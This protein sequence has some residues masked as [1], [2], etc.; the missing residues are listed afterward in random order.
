MDGKG[1]AIGRLCTWLVLLLLVTSGAVSGTTAMGTD[2]S[3]ATL[4]EPSNR[5]RTL[6]GIASHR[7][8]RPAVNAEG[9]SHNHTEVGNF[10]VEYI[11]CTAVR[12]TGTGTIHM[13]WIGYFEYG[14][15]Y[16]EVVRSMNGTEIV[17]PPTE[18][19][20]D[21]PSDDLAF[22]ERGYISFVDDA[23]TTATPSEDA[24]FVPNRRRCIREHRPAKVSVFVQN[25]TAIDGGSYRVTFGYVNP[26][27]HV[28]VMDPPYMHSQLSYLLSDDGDGLVRRETTADR[29]K[30][31]TRTADGPPIRLEPGRH[32]FTVGWSPE[33]GDSRLVWVLDL[34]YF[35]W[36]RVTASTPPASQVGTLGTTLD[37]Y[38]H[39]V[40]R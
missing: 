33:C 8:T 2:S 40:Y 21:E 35:G 38:D 31:N 16:G 12:V 14:R 3:A 5:E 39:C 4:F 18:D 13:R 27:E 20:D 26:N 15:N 10:T 36:G 37:E 25:V 30:S 22:N 32:T 1:V 23:N 19:K 17:R 34:E 9:T 28:M 6:D 11:N 7:P 29:R 24:A